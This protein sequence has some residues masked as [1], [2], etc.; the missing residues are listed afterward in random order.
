MELK[1]L[2]EA[3]DA[4]PESRRRDYKK[5][6]SLTGVGGKVWPALAA[7]LEAAGTPDEFFEAVYEDDACRFENLWAAWAKL[8]HKRWAKRFEPLQTVE[9]AK[10]SDKGVFLEGEHAQIL[11]PVQG[12][13]R[14]IDVYVF[15]EDGFNSEA[16]DLYLCVNGSFECF[17]MKIEGTFDVYV[18]ERMVLIEMWEMD[19]A[20]RRVSSKR[21]CQQE[22]CWH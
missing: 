13:N 3:I 5:L 17:G 10:L 6:L 12:R 16:A 9:G 1:E 11:I 14:P 20:G 21:R 4:M 8:T 22:P 18:A 2:R 7:H 15:G 19:E